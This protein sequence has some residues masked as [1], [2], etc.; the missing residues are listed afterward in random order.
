[1]EIKIV[2]GITLAIF[3]LYIRVK[4]RIGMPYR[5]WD[6]FYHMFVADIIRKTGNRK[7]SV[8]YFIILL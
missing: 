8:N 4:P 1:M 6:C 7:K 3:G 2:I 5:G